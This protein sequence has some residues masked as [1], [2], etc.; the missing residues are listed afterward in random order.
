MTERA[1]WM[2]EQWVKHQQEGR[3]EEIEEEEELDWDGEEDF[4]RPY[5]PMEPFVREKEKVGRNDPCP[6]GS[7]K[8]FKRCC[9]GKGIYD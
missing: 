7:G 3:Y 2:T 5:E 9:M 8:K 4:S 6:C 1:G